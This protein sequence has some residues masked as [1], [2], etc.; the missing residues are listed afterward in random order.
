MFLRSINPYSGEIL[1]IFQPLSGPQIEAAASRARDAFDEWSTSDISERSR[2]LHSCGEELSGR[3]MHYA[4]LISQEMGKVITEAVAEIDK[5]AHACHY[6]AEHGPSFIDAEELE[7]PSGRAR[8]HYQPLGVVLAVMPWNFPFWQV[9][10]FAA[11]ALM[12][13]NTALLKHASNVPL[14]ALA[15]E[16]VFR[17]AGLPEGIFQSLLIGSNAVE[18]LVAD[19]RISSVTLTGSEMAGSAVASTA[20]RYLK[21]TVLELGG[22]DPFI[23]LEDADAETAAQWAARARMIN[24]GQSCIAAKRFIVHESIADSFREALIWQLRS[25]H[26][27]NPMNAE[28]DYACLSSTEQARLVHQQVLKSIS[29]G[30]RILEGQLP[31]RVESAVIHP[32]VLDK[33]QPGMPLFNEEIFGPVAPIF[34][35]RRDTEAISISNASDYGLGASVWSINADRA[36]LLANRLQCGAVYINQ[37]VFSHPAVPFGGVKKSGYGRELSYLGMREFTNPKSIWQA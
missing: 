19:S 12:A 32:L 29:M 34:T 18:K 16:A 5:C 17:N 14:C 11:P 7:A 28:S 24:C 25:L 35:F 15:I 30:A 36:E 33:V 21:K 27:G 2:L 26:F 13:G 6:F 37:M 8:L 22:S 10:R 20:G 31:E 3:R 9:F 23:V 4:S 1:N